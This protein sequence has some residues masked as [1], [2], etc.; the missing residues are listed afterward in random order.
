MIM[1]QDFMDRWTFNQKNLMKCCKEFP[2]WEPL[3]WPARGLDGR[4][5]V[6]AWASLDGRNINGGVRLAF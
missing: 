4:C 1:A 2:R 6:D 3:L 5:T